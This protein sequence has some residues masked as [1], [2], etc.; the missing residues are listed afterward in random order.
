MARPIKDGIDYF[1]LDVDFFQDDKIRLLKAEFGAKGITILVAL[2]CDIYRTNGYY[3]VWDNDACL[4]MA[5]AVGCG[6]VPENITQ[7]VQG[8][9]RRS[10]FD[11]GVFQM[12]GILTSA[13][14]QRRYIQAVSTR[15]EIRFIKE[16]WLL[17]LGDKKDVPTSTSKKVTFKSVNLKETTVNLKETPVNLQNNP[18]SKVKK[19]KVKK[20]IGES[21]PAEAEPDRK[22]VIEI[23]LN[24][25]TTYHVYEE[26]ISEWKE[27]YPGVDIKQQLR[28]M[29]GWCISNPT[30]RK[31]QRGILRFITGWLAKEQD[32]SK[33]AKGKY[34]PNLTGGQTTKGIPEFPPPEIEKEQ[35]RHEEAM[36]KFR[37]GKCGWEELIP[38]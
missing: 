1:P 20:S 26:Q 7:V 5:D 13:G 28:N 19:S 9:L 17:D 22:S 38:K 4:L 30:R 21:D 16:Y 14:I 6:I 37:E 27:L 33:P 8:C 34:E 15:E 12:F 11:D 10:I 24:D 18:Q 25:G 23:P 36:R 29:K 31:T 3:K 32:R 2:L 35:E